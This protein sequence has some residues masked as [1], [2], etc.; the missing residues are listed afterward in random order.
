MAEDEAGAAGKLGLAL[1]ENEIKGSRVHS[2]Y[3]KRSL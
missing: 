2:T 3:L 1:W